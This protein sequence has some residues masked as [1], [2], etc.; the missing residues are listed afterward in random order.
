M[1]NMRCQ[2]RT[3]HIATSTTKRE[4]SA[5]LACALRD[6]VLKILTFEGLRQQCN[7]LVV[8][9]RD[10]AGL[11]LFRRARAREVAMLAVRV[12]TGVMRAMRPGVS[13]KHVHAWHRRCVSCVSACRSADAEGV[14]AHV[15][16]PSGLEYTDER[17]GQGER[18]REGVSCHV[19][20][21]AC[22]VVAPALA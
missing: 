16:T 7:T 18:P 4:G 19:A 6:I 13:G 15:V 10:L 9:A 12:G 2:G 21:V 20:A 1:A 5:E 14:G 17:V 8:D 22:C 11:P 3:T